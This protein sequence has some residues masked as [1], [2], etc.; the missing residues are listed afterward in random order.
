MSKRVLIIRLG[1][2][3]D[4]VETTGLLRA[5]KN[6]GCEIDYLTGNVP[7]QLLAN[8]FDIKNL[9]IFEKKDY[10]YIFNLGLRL[11]QLDYD[12]ILNLQPS[13]RLRILSR[14]IGAKKIVNYQKSYNFHAVENFFATGKKIFPDLKLDKNL[15]LYI[16]PKI[17]E[18]MSKKLNNKLKICFNTGANSSRQGRKWC[19]DYWKKLADL[20]LAKYDAEIYVIGAKDDEKNVNELVNYLPKIKSFAGKTSIIETAALLSCADIVISGDTGPL[21]IASA[22]DTVCIGLYGCCSISRSGPYGEKHFTISSGLNCSPCDKRTCKFLNSFIDD[23]PCMREI[24]P[25]K[26]LNLVDTIISQK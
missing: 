4:V 11:R 8:D 24:K 15:H 19:I 12:V 9:F 23:A 5:L 1:A 6:I 14:I 22:T 26:V 18:E 20:I 2:I 16:P 3:G 25:E 21:H 17:K 7:G 13:L 10:K